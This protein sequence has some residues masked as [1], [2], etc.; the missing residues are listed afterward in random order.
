[1][2]ESSY[3]VGKDYTIITTAGWFKGKL[4]KETALTLTLE[5]VSWIVET[6]QFSEFVQDD[7]KVLEEES[8]RDTPFIIER[9]N[10]IGGIPMKKVVQRQV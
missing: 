1:M 10:I 8:F 4:A 5:N 7:S 3:E 6:K 2:E 9:A